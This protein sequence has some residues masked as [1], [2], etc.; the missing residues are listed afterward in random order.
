MN[1][2]NMKIFRIIFLVCITFQINA[3][4]FN[5]GESDVGSGNCHFDK[6]EPHLMRTL[7]KTSEGEYV[8]LAYN[9][10][11]SEKSS[12]LRLDN[13]DENLRQTVSKKIYWTKRGHS[14]TIKAIV[15]GEDKFYVFHAIYN[16]VEKSYTLYAQTIDVSGKMIGEDKIITKYEGL[17]GFK[18]GSFFITKSDDRSHIGILSIPPFQKKTNETVH[19]TV[20]DKNLK[21]VTNQE[22]AFDFP[23]KRIN[24]NVPYVDN[25][26]TFYM[27]KQRKDKDKNKLKEVYVLGASAKEYSKINVDLGD[28]ELYGFYQVVNKSNGNAVLAGLMQGYNPFYMELGTS[29]ELLKTVK[30]EFEGSIPAIGTDVDFILQ[31][32]VVASNDD[33]L[34]L[35]TVKSQEVKMGSDNKTSI[36]TYGQHNFYTARLNSEGTV[37]TKF[38]GRGKLTSLR[39]AG[40]YLGGVSYYDSD[41]DV[42]VVV[43]NNLLKHYDKERP[44]STYKIPVVVTIEG[45][46]KMNKKGL[47]NAGLGVMKTKN[48]IRKDT[49]VLLPDESYVIDGKFMVKCGSRYGYK[50]GIMNW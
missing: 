16:N 10:C 37:W 32:V 18:T 29:N 6:K 33:I 17:K 50:L 48:G 9:K 19:V 44:N 4:T 15:A 41:K 43:F 11:N 45:N 42:F 34:F 5:W 25:N 28:D 36:T 30:G 12:K 7:L 24:Y 23:R 49:H 47:P 38:I 13:F 39:D 8:R 3:Q 22:M 31:E 35:A 21:T 14:S 40:C 46:G 20:L 1:L 27:Y 26:G 2:F